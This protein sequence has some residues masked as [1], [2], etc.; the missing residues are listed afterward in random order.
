MDSDKKINPPDIKMPHPLKDHIL[1]AGNELRISN[2]TNHIKVL[3]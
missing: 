3:L 1:E 2:I